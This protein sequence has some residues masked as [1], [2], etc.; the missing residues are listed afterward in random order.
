MS[1]F[2]SMGTVYGTLLNFRA[3]Y[4]A[5]APRM[6]DPPYK[7]PPKAPVLY[8][9]PANTWSADGAEIVVPAGVKEFEVGAT[10]GMIVGQAG[11][12]VGYALMNDLFIPHDSFFRPPVKYRCLDGT[13]GVGDT[14]L[15][16]DGEAVDPA[17]FVLTV[18][19]NGRLEQTIHFSG[20][21]RSAP[22]LLADVAEFMT[23][24]PGDV[25]L[26]GQDAGRPRARAGDVIELSAD[27]LGTLTNT[28][29]AE[30]A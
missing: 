15:R 30:A 7:G 10:I 23:L 11:Q 21:V 2:L 13:L 26:L 17:S 22:Q 14:L 4:D 20:L 6:A 28:L 24:G 3:E 9:K 18:R 19:I 27:G 1:N 29:V 25:L 12:P 16:T 8:I 5:W